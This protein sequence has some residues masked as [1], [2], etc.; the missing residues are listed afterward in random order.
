MLVGTYLDTP[1]HRYVDGERARF[2]GRIH[3]GRST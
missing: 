3:H 2:D 1:F